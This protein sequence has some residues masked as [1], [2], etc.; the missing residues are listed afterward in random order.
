MT[1]LKRY[2][3][4]V[5][6]GFCI[7][8]IVY[9]FSFTKRTTQETKISPPEVMSCVKNVKTIHRKVDSATAKLLVE[10]EN[11]SDLGIVAISLEAKKGK[12]SYIVRESTFEAAEPTIIIKPHERH[13]LEI[14]LANSPPQA[15]FQIG[16]VVYVDGTEDGCEASVQATREAK[17]HHEKIK[18]QKK[19]LK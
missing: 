8:G 15:Q 7:G 1:N 18:A 12:D 17:A 16:S 14:E 13:T 6:L 2:F 3:L 19:G 9:V 5:F 11:T 10:V 4:A